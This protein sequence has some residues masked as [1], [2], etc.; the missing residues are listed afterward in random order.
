MAKDRTGSRLI[1]KN[2][3]LLVR[4]V[5]STRVVKVFSES[6]FKALKAATRDIVDRQNRRKNS[7]KEIGSTPARVL[8][9]ID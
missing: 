4:K 3:E 7:P 1:F 2:I 5:C 9:S 6:H 8:S